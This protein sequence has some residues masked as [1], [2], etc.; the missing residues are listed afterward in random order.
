MAVLGRKSCAFACCELIVSLKTLLPM[1][2]LLKTHIANLYSLLSSLSSAWALWAP[3]WHPWGFCIHPNIWHVCES[4]LKLMGVYVWLGAVSGV[5]C[6]IMQQLW[7]E[8]SGF[9]FSTND[10]VLCCIHF[11][12]WQD[13]WK[14]KLQLVPS[15][16]FWGMFLVL[17]N[18]LFILYLWP[19][20]QP[21]RK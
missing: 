6:W 4:L 16:N 3:Q 11:S 20:L 19:D 1:P 9:C 12:S 21:H 18:S 2:F 5:N 7:Q 14:V 15:G 8:F 17:H 10:I 13:C